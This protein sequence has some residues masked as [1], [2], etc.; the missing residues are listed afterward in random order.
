MPK[1][2]EG[3]FQ[4]W[5]NFPLKFRLENR[6]LKQTVNWICLIFNSFSAIKVD[7]DHK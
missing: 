1:S 4:N 5:F 6:N 2:V 7:L 3:I